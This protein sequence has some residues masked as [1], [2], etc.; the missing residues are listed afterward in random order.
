MCTDNFRSHPFFFWGGGALTYAGRIYLRCRGVTKRCRLFW[1]ANGAPR[2]WAIDNPQGVFKTNY[3][4]TT[5]HWSPSS[6][7]FLTFFFAANC[8]MEEGPQEC[9]DK[10]VSSVAE[11]PQ[12][13]YWVG[14]NRLFK[15]RV[16]W[17]SISLSCTKF[18]RLS[19]DPRNY[20][21]L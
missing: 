20:S 13:E 9:H 11:V 10:M 16:T 8:R 1:L 15:G 21:F 4:M 12:G 2:L 5:M 6:S 18:A 7:I 14:I 17:A 3:V 19:A